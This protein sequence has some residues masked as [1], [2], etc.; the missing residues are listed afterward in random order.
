MSALVFSYQPA[1][2]DGPSSVASLPGRI[3]KRRVIPSC[4][5]PFPLA[6]NMM[7]ARDD[8]TIPSAHGRAWVQP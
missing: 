8:A 4:R 2:P 3:R 5:R 7:G 1:V 6:R